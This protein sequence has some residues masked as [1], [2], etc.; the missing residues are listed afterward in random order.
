MKTWLAFNWGIGNRHGWGVYGLNLTLQCL[1]RGTPIPMPL[2]DI[3]YRDLAPEHQARLR[4]LL[5]FR[6]KTM[7]KRGGRLKRGSHFSDC[8]MMHGLGN[9]M[10]RGKRSASFRGD[11]NIG[12]IFSEDTNIDN[13]DMDHARSFAGIV[14]GST[15]NG[16]ILR[17]RGLKVYDVFQGIDPT[18]FR[19]LPRE[20]RYGDRFAVFSGGKLEFRKSQDIVLAA[21]K[22]FHERHPDSL[23]LTAWHNPWPQL[24]ASMNAS[25][26]LKSLPRIDSKNRLMIEEWAH[27]SGIPKEAFVDLGF[28]PNEQ[29]PHVMSEIDL[30]V[31]P[32]RGEGGT[33]LVAMEAMACGVPCILAANTGQVDLIT[34]DNCYSLHDQKPVVTP[35]MG[36]EG[37]GECSIEEL[38]ERMEQ[39]YTDRENAKLRGRK[40]AEFMLGWSW[41]NQIGLLLETLENFR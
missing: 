27:A 35:D 29:T 13:A 24:V 7:E 40:A 16:D 2:I 25:P 20:G 12:V 15:W 41:K 38:V 11:I 30:A 37:W 32:N 18:I 34:E 8:L 5:E 4:P 6:R 28:I 1:E 36:T 31:F 3:G 22:I 19:P 39:A 10:A 9:N 33:N 17:S 26:H 21:F 14:A 23:L